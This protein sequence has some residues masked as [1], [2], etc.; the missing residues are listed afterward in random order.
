MTVLEQGNLKVKIINKSRFI[1]TK[2]II[3]YFQLPKTGKEKAFT[4]GTFDSI[5]LTGKPSNFTDDMNSVDVNE[6][7]PKLI[8][9]INSL[10]YP[11]QKINVPMIIFQMERK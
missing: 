3:H 8:E 1:V 10:Q 9:K 7:T 2:Q 5:P 6:I 4:Y 11:G